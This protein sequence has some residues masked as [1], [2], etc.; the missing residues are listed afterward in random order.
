MTIAAKL[1]E[2]IKAVCPIRGI[3]IGREDDKTTWR[4]NFKDEA[5]DK[6]R[7]DARAVLEAFDVE[8][9]SAPVIDKRQAAIEALLAE[10]AKRADA[11]QAVKDYAAKR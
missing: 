7:A 2:A 8:D 11:P 6:Q 3:S 5:T 9:A 10:Q 4:I 1:D